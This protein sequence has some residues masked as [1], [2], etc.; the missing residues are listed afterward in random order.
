MPKIA[1]TKSSLGKKLGS[2]NALTNKLS[3]LAV[4]FIGGALILRSI[5]AGNTNSVEDTTQNPATF[6]CKQTPDNELTTLDQS[7][8]STITEIASIDYQNDVTSTALTKNGIAAIFNPKFVNFADVDACIGKDEE[9]LVISEAD[10][11]QIYP[12]TILEQHLVVNSSIKGMPVIV[13]YCPLCDSYAVY[14]SD[15]N[16]EILTF[17]VSGKLYKNS[18]FL[19]DVR[20]ESLWSQF[21][22]VARVGNLTGASLEPKPFLIMSYADAKASFPKAQVLSFDTGYRRNY[23]VLN[24]NAFLEN[25]QIVGKIINSNDKLPLKEK[26]LGFFLNN[27][28]Y[29]VKL[30]NVKDKQI[31]LDKIAGQ[32]LEISKVNGVLQISFGGKVVETQIFPALWYVWYDF[33]PETQLLK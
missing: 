11:T 28:P 33:Y 3:I 24:D 23:H 25:N 14:A 1:E 29:A 21:D 15:Y 19:F 22:G 26:I 30:S 5:N 4:V 9:V 7:D 31:Y 12:K 32:R 13:T 10:Q 16:H 18:D 17:G 20:T 6:A 27:K 8:L 2:F